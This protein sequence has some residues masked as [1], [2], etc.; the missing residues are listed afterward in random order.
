MKS[1]MERYYQLERRGPETRTSNKRTVKNRTLYNSIYDDVEYSNIEG[2]A[3]ID[4]KNEIDVKKIKELLKSKE[5]INND[6]KKELI[7]KREARRKEDPVEENRTYDIRD[8]LSKAKESRQD[9][10][11]VNKTLRNTQY[12]MLKNVDLNREIKRRENKFDEVEE[13][14]DIDELVDT[15]TS[16]KLLDDLAD[17]ELSLDLL[18]DLKSNDGENYDTDENT[19]VR[20][21]MDLDND[22]KNISKPEEV[23]S[24]KIDKSFFT[25]GI[26][27]DKEDFEQALNEEQ[28]EEEGKILLK[29]FLFVFFILLTIA[30]AVG[31][32]IFFS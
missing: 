9:E 25:S 27:F 31:L 19:S 2:V 21:V 29:I 14:D 20:R 7:K 30:S 26:S 13:K 17:K 10:P 11:S 5:E 6:R 1:R 32:Y 12:D 23:K 18:D 4:I 3:D 16:S 24:D 15:I 8:I 28:T 22:Y